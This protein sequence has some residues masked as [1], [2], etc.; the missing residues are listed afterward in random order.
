LNTENN[1]SND[2]S[3]KFDQ[4]NSDQN[5]ENDSSNQNKPDNN[6][7]NT[8][9]EDS[10]KEE[11][12]RIESPKA[13]PLKIEPPKEEPL[14]EEPPK[15]EPSKEE[16]PKEEPLKEE[17]LKEEP[18]KEEPLK[19]EPLKEEP[20]KE[21][22]PKEEKENDGKKEATFLGLRVSAWIEI[23][24]FV[25]VMS[26]FSFIL[27]V[28]LNYFGIVP[29]P[30]WILVILMSAQYGVYEGIMAAVVATLILLLGPIPARNVL[31]DR[32]D[33][34]FFL[35]KTPMIWLV[36]A[37]ILG[38]IRSR[39]IQERDELR[40]KAQEAEE[41]QDVIATSYNALKN[42]KERLEVR[43]SSE[44]Q[45]A[46]M[47]IKAFKELE[48]R[49]VDAIIHGTIDLVKALVAPEVFSIYLLE[50]D[51]LK[52]V[53]FIGDANQDDFASTFDA[54]SNL[55]KEIV[56]S[57]KVVSLTT[58]G[59]EFLGREGLV[60]APIIDSSNGLIFGMIKIEQ[61]PFLRLRSSTMD[62][63]QSIGEMAG[64][65]YSRNV[66]TKGENEKA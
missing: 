9:K 2:D 8:P 55:Y 39:H 30:Y 61:I 47:E 29:N 38:S 5:N 49:G 18:L 64:I 60:A 53:E 6:M 12:L 15:E 44:M 46:L 50:N 52:R 41:K 11:P 7:M 66:Q 26:V 57:K 34:F 40:K 20:P 3:N 63:L 17:P 16:P 31:Q 19:E 54:S 65:S 33:F 42:I 36:S 14:K 32:F 21:E 13:E 45:T 23:L 51:V 37:T 1:D 10:P 35:A 56:A 22:P 58:S 25:V 43:L 62:T 27:N 48:D 24:V 59:T 4:N 28:K